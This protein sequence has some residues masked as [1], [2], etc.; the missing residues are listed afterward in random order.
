VTQAVAPSDRVSISPDAVF[1]ELDG[2]G[3]V[4]NLKSGLYF[5]LNEVGT[6]IWRLIEE[7]GEVGRILAALGEEFDAPE[8]RLRQD[9]HELIDRLREKGLVHVEPHA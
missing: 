8:D 9:L 4:L 3:V 5:G 6:R 7:H 1:R 2:E